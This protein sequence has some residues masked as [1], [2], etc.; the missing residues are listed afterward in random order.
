MQTRPAT[1]IY[2]PITIEIGFVKAALGDVVNVLKHWAAT[3]GTEYPHTYVDGGLAQNIRRLEPL[4][5]VGYPRKLVVATR[6]PEWVAEFDC[7]ARGGD[8]T[9]LVGYVAGVLNTEG[10]CVMDEPY[11]PADGKGPYGA[12]QLTM[13]GPQGHYFLNYVRSVSVVQD[14]GKFCFDQTGEV[15]PFEDVSAYARRRVRDRFTPEMLVQYTAAMGL[16]PFDVD[17]YIGPSALV[18]QP[19][20]AAFQSA[21]TIEDVQRARYAA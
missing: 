9:T 3:P 12:C 5:V 8:P 14:G 10:V 21:G 18:E 20:A 19:S 2:W 6:N 16:A 7:G 15:Q 1:D 11:R 13:F 4:T 17:F